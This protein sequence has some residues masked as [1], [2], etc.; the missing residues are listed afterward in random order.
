MEQ[1]NL[2]KQQNVGSSE[3]L[4]SSVL[5][6]MLAVGALRHV[7]SPRGWISGILAYS[8]LKRG[9]TGHCGLYERLGVDSTPA[10]LE[11]KKGLLDPHPV[12]FGANVTIWRTIQEVYGTCRDISGWRGILPLLQS[13]QRPDDR[14]WD[15]SF[16]TPRGR[17]HLLS[18][19]LDREEPDRLL[20][21]VGSSDT[22][23]RVR[24]IMEFVPA[25]R[26]R[27]TGGTEVSL[28]LT[29]VPPVGA[30]GAGVIK[31]LKP[32]LEGRFVDA[33][34]YRL[35]QLIETGEVATRAVIPSL[36]SAALVRPASRSLARA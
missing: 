20:S 11:L 13:V 17:C 25:P 30:V 35:K 19:W 23:P 22:L 33:S 8:M 4:V 10:G 28:T 9:L 18:L 24:G 2:H 15:L 6:G 1:T 16:T 12:D 5:G 14:H 32:L 21:W 31:A 29:V 27:E 34:L 7:R 36:E 3:R 26:G